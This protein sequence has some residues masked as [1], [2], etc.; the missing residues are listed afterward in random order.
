M[1]SSTARVRVILDNDF[2]GDPDGLF[3]LAH[4]LLCRTVEI[5]FVIVSK[6]SDFF[7]AVDPGAIE[8]GR[9]SVERVMELVGRSVPIHA[10]PEASVPADGKPQLTDGA[11]AII[12]EAMRDDPRPLFYAAGGGLTELAIALA[13]EPRIADRLTLA[14]IGGSGYDGSSLDD[15]EFNLSIDPAAA[16]R[17]FRSP[18]SIWQVPETTYAQ[19]LVSWAELDRDVA[20][21]SAVGTFR[22]FGDRLRGLGADFADAET[23]V[24]GDSPLVVLTA[25]AGP[26]APGRVSSPSVSVDRRAIG[27]DGRYGEVFPGLPPVRVFTAIDTR[28]MYGDMVAKFGA[29]S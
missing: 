2:G 7:A 24:L 15:V 16:A 19:C 10:G 13:H 20:G 28:L 6:I 21:C 18:L 4:H 9:A 8:R 14:W 3:Q 26:H 11:R 12:A 27:A 1:S 25:L 17:V 29:I 23:A 22:E 5:P